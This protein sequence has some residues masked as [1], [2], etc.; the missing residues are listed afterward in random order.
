MNERARIEADAAALQ[1][2][3]DSRSSST[4]TPVMLKSIALPSMCWLN[5]ATPRERRR[6]IWIGGGRTVGRDDADRLLGAD[7]AHHFPQD[8][9]QLRV[10]P[11]EVVVAP[12][13]QEVVELLQPVFVVA[14]VALEGDGDLVVAVGVLERDR[15]G[16]AVRH[17]VLQRA[18]GD[19]QRQ[20][21]NA[22]AAETAR[23]E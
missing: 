7:L 15:A 19:D 9:E 16:V 12:V 10:H 18:G 11:R 17:H 2:Q 20:R 13:A 14:A 1:P 5:W 4:G 22:G 8:V 6:S 21:R 3:R 23:S